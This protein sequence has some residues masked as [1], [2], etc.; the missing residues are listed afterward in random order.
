MHAISTDRNSGDY[1]RRSCLSQRF[2]GVRIRSTDTVRARSTL[3]H[4]PSA[5][6]LCVAPFC[7]AIIISTQRQLRHLTSL[8][9]Q[10]PDLHLKKVESLSLCDF[11]R[12]TNKKNFKE[13]IALI[14]LLQ[15]HASFRRLLID[16]KHTFRSSTISVRP[17]TSMTHDG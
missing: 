13:M 3:Q 16:H 10:S 6:S 17:S 14:E 8:L 4:K 2:A 9:Y 12:S 5:T 7:S 15:F 1:R 11:E